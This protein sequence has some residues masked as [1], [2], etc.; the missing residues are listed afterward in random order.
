MNIPFIQLFRTPNAYYF[1]DVNKD[2]ILP[3]G[4]DLFQYLHA[5]LNNK[6]VD[7]LDL[8]EELVA[9]KSQGYLSSDSV[10]NNIQHPISQFLEVFLQRKLPKITIL[11]LSEVS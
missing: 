9:L 7:T 2:E 11:L 1:L 5:I 10:V 6:L 4:K 8:P 3:I